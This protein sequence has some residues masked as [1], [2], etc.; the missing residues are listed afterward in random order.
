[1][2]VISINISVVIEDE[3][4]CDRNCPFL[5]GNKCILFHV[6]LDETQLENPYAWQDGAIPTRQRDYRCMYFK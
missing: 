1:M 6:E 5:D 3:F 2:D 4:T